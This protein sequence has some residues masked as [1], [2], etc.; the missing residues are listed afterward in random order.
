[1]QDAEEGIVFFVYGEDEDMVEDVE[2]EDTYSNVDTDGDDLQKVKVDSNFEGDDDF[3]AVVSGLDDDTDYYFR[4]CVQFEDED[5]DDRLV[6]G[7]VEDFT[8][9]EY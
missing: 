7:D 4:L 5:D 6:C 2:D 3:Y 1:M 9:D 8:T